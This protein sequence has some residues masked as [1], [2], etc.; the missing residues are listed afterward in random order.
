MNAHVLTLA[1]TRAEAEAAMAGDPFES[2][3]PAC[4][5]AASET[6]LGWTLSLY[7]TD[8]PDASLIARLAALAPSARGQVH[9]EDLPPRDWVVESQA[10]LAPVDAGRFHV[11]PGHRAGEARPG[12]IGIRINAGRAFGTGQHATTRGCLL[13]IENRLKQ[14]RL[15]RV[16]DL[17]TG[18]AVLAIA[19]A[20]A[21]R[22]TRPVATDIDPVAVTVAVTNARAN[23]APAIIFAA[24]AGLDLARIRAGAPYDLVLANILAG[25]LIALSVGMAAVVRPGGHVVLAGL[26]ARQ[27]RAVLAAYLAQGFRRVARIGGEWP[28]LLL[29][30]RGPASGRAR[31]SRAIA[32]RAARR[33]RAAAWRSAGSI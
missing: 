7:C 21:D 9:V 18:S 33:G 14:G 31:W 19:V 8:R 30:R 13:I 23:R 3:E 20:R 10:G 29:R 1:C 17:G 11:Y 16:L 4:V 5:L 26:L 28:V 6:D 25:P 15:G 12:Q 22:C 32:V 24:G 27:E 2:E